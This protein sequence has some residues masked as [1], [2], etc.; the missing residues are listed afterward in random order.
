MTCFKREQD[1]QTVERDTASRGFFTLIELLVV[2]AIIAILASMLLPAL[3]QAREKAR[4]ISC[5]ANIR[6]Q[7]T[8]V[9]LYLDDND[10]TWG[11]AMLPG[12]DGTT[13]YWYTIV[14]QYLGQC[15]DFTQSSLQTQVLDA[16]NLGVLRCPSDG[17]TT[18]AGNPYPNYTFNSRA[19][20]VPQGLDHR[21]FSTIKNPSAIM[22]SMD[23]IN[24]TYCANLNYVYRTHPVF[25]LGGDYYNGKDMSRYARHNGVNVVYVDG[26]AARVNRNFLYQVTSDSYHI[27]W[28]LEQTH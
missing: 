6:Q 21:K 27:F 10:N 15:N 5:M 3:S 14:A 28:D 13:T 26:H 17:T 11:T 22:M 7:G 25:T 4:S 20:N 9:M 1:K 24:N 18:A 2:I 12:S 16:K 23:G 8:A 19:S